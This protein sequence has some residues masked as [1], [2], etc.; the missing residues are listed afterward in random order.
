MNLTRANRRLSVVSWVLAAMAVTSTVSAQPARPTLFLS[1]ASECFE[2]YLKQELS[3]FDFTNHPDRAS[4]NLVVSRQPAGHGGELFTVNM[5]TSGHTIGPL[6][7][8]ATF[9]I[10]RSAQPDHVRHQL[11]QALLRVL[12]AGLRGTVYDAA[13][14]LSVPRRDGDRLSALADRWDYWTFMPQLN[15]S[16][17]GGSGYYFI[18]ATAGVTA[19]RITDDIKV[20]LRGN[21]NRSWNGFRPE[22]ETL[23]HG[24]ISGWD[25]RGLFA[26]SLGRFWGLGTVAAVRANQFEN[27][28]SHV[29][30]GPLAEYNVFPYSE[31]AF[32]QLRV[33]YQAGVWT[34]RYLEPNVAGKLGE[35]RGY[36]ALSLIVDANQPWGSVQWAMQGNQ[37]LDDPDKFR[38][39]AGAVLTLRVVEGVALAFEGQGAWVKDQIGLRG[40]VITERELTLWTAEQ[41]T[42]FTFEG[43]LALVYTFGSV[44]NTIVNPRFARVDLDEE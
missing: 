31:N 25:A 6:P 37:F 42:N 11:L 35:S 12:Y 22:G 24:T 4:V 10:E 44:H 13:F 20:R 38:L 33:A 28:E 7:A 1:C 29:H 17:E 34:N 27:L 36:H 8:P 9:T 2:T 18:S 32:A 40:R 19:R 15:A 3:Y 16:G 39:S 21:Y 41:A 23:K 14:S 5:A 26:Y 30:A 43:K